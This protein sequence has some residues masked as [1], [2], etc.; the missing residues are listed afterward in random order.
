MAVAAD[1]APTAAPDAPAPLGATLGRY[2]CPLAGGPA[3]R[4][5]GVG[6]VGADVEA[7]DRAEPRAERVGPFGELPGLPALVGEPDAP[8]P[9]RAGGAE[10]GR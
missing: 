6:A 1:A 2:G 5:V 7:V 10:L 3:G 4:A 8:A 9:L